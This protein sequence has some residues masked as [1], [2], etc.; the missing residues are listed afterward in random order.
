LGPAAVILGPL[1]IHARD[2][3]VAPH[4][5]G[6]GA[7]VAV[8]YALVVLR[9]GER[10]GA[11][12]VAQRQEGQLF[13]LEELLEHDLGVAET[14]LGEEDVEGRAGLA[15]VGGDDHALPRRQDVGLEHGRV[16]GAS[17]VGD[18]LLAVAEQHVRG[19]RHAAALHQLLGVGLRALDARRLPRRPERRDT[20]LR[21]VVHYPGHERRLGAH[22]HEVDSPLARRRDEIVRRQALH[23]VTGDPDIA[24]GGQ[25]LRGLRAA[26]QRAD[27]RVLAPAAADNQDPLH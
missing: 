10:H 21:Q 20:G 24:G 26:K 2:R 16:G 23:A 14:P 5:A 12:A 25:D 1:G 18:R 27:E 7:L 4:A 19:G 13:T 9:G 6:V 3:R 17:H 8:E 15:L 11:L 22:D